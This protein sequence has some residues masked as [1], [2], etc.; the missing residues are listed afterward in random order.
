MANYKWFTRIHRKL[1]LL[2]KGKIGGNLGGR[3]MAL[4][5]TIGRKT[6][7]E[8]IVPLVYYSIDNRGPIVLGSNNGNAKPPI[9]WLNLQHTPT[10]TVQIGADKFQA[11][12]QEIEEDLREEY[13]AKMVAVNPIIKDYPQ[14]SGRKL[15]IVL[16]VKE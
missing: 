10:I 8:R 16:L 7:Q 3:P 11:Q 1:Y 9:W 14:L 15:P 2:T 6:G 12:A 13:W 4:L 5:Y